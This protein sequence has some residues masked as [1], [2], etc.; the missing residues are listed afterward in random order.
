MP[1]RPPRPCSWPG[2]PLL[3]T[4]RFC[5]THR[6][7]YE[8]ERERLRG[9]RPTAHQRGYDGAWRRVRAQV[10]AEEPRCRMCG[11]PASEVD[12]IVPLA[13]GGTH[14]RANL[15]P[16]CVSCHRI[17]S[18]R[19][20]DPRRW[21]RP[22]DPQFA[23]RQRD[24]AARAGSVVVHVCGAPASGKTTL[25]QALDR[26]LGLPTFGIDDER[27]ALLAPGAVWT[28]DDLAAWCRLEDA[29]DA[30]SPCVVETSGRHGN[31]ALMLAGRQ[32]LTVL[33]RAD[34]A[35]RRERLA[36]RVAE[37]YPLARG[38]TDYVDRLMRIG[39]PALTPDVVWDSSRPDD[40]ALANVIQAVERF[41]EAATAR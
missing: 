4:Q 10:L 29:L 7:V 18:A 38:V 2:C 15:Q 5:P 31:A 12:H 25:R 30:E 14:D 19:A 33:C 40:A 17:K 6:R 37:G 20:R 41:L 32:V 21:T 28:G 22:R 26:E 23:A 24:L 9:R 1:Y 34:D 8:R 16:L 3:T 36:A 39:D 13:R 27:L 11:A 35:V